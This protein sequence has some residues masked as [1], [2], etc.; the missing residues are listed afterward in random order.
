MTKWAGITFWDV[1][2]QTKATVKSLKEAQNG[3]PDAAMLM[4]CKELSCKLDELHRLMNHMRVREQ[5]SLKM[6]IKIQSTFT[7]RHPRDV[8]EII[9]EL[10]RQRGLGDFG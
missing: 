7:I 9:F 2:R 8:E 10:M 3:T 6:V 1:K 5:T 4:R